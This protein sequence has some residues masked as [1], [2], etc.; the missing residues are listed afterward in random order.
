MSEKKKQASIIIPS[1]IPKIYASGAVGNFSLVD[2]RILFF[3]EEA[4][5]HDEF[6]NPTEIKSMAEVKL[7]LVLPPVAA[8]SIAS[9]LMKQVE[10]YEQKFGPINQPKPNL[11]ESQ[12]TDEEK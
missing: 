4:L 8:K 2:F 6:L 11:Q 12:K 5:Q 10:L 1:G 3:T 9:W 7:Q